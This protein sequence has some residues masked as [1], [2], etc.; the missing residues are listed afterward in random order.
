MA[1]LNGQKKRTGEIIVS[2]S[3]ALPGR[4]SFPQNEKVPE[5]K[6]QRKGWDIDGVLGLRSNVPSMRIEY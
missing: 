5:R 1:L 2:S 3:L 6:C 4:A